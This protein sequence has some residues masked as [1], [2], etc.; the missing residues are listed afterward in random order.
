M[1][2]LL[3][4]LVATV[5][6]A[7]T[8]SV[9]LYNNL[10]DYHRA[11]STKVPMTQRYFDQGLRLAYAFNHEE[12]IK[13]FRE[14]ARR[15]PQCAMCWWGVAYAYGPN[16]NMP[17][18]SAGNAQ[19]GE[20]V[21]KAKALLAHASPAERAMILAVEKRYGAQAGPAGDSAYARAMRDVAKQFPRDQDAQVIAADAAMMLRPW[22]YW[23]KDG[24]PYPGTTEL[25]A[26]LE[27]VIAA[28]PRNPG[29]CHFYIHAV[30]ATQ[31]EKA[32][33][34]AE[35]LASLMPGAGHLVHMPAHIYIRVGR[36]ND[37]IEANK[38]AVHADDEFLSVEK[39]AGVYPLAYYPHNHHF[40]AFAA[41]MVGRS[42]L[43]LEHAMH[44]S[45]SIPAEP[46]A[47]FPVLQP[48]VAYP[49]LTM[50]TFGMWDE[51]L[52]SQDPAATLPIATALATYAKGVAHAVK[53]HGDV[54]RQHL[55][56]VA[57]IAEDVKSDAGE[58]DQ[59]VDIA[60]HALAGEIAYRAGNLA[61][62]ET[63]FRAAMKIE[64]AF[65]YTEPPQWNYPIRHS[66]A[67][68]LSEA[69]RH[70]EAEQLLRE[71]LRRFPGNVWALTGLA[72]ALHAQNKH[73]EAAATEKL[74]AA[75]AQHADVKFTKARF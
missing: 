4:A 14:A 65:N 72:T 51:L 21:K 16:I 45:K 49:Q 12:A 56:R 58:M 18:D 50:L 22:N 3:F 38:H 46:A 60:H 53:G 15:D 69:K 6:L 2:S 70:A 36:W 23:T 41:A 75:A 63:H 64:D 48:L 17:M 67:A 27:R 7:A 19:A 11:I 24:K 1:T 8:D 57:Q 31:P 54:A 71:D 9:R 61:E 55:A 37:A 33:A 39:P 59:V 35:R 5:Q 43:A 25:V 62:A 30:E 66:L 10:G 74:L 68:A 28:N 52:S 32:V 29:A 20:A 40:L 26:A 47:A 44:T 42:A 34:C 13:S 73:T